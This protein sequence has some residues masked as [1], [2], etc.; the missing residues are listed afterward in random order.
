MKR[1]QG[2]HL[3]WAKIK[4]EILKAIIDGHDTRE[5]LKN[6]FTNIVTRKDIDYHLRGTP[7]KPGLIRRGVLKE[8]DGRL[9]INLRN[10]ESLE[11]ILKDYLLGLPEYRRALDL[12]FSAC[13]LSEH[14]DFLLTHFLTE[15][16]VLTYQ[17]YHYWATYNDVNKGEVEQRFM[18]LAEKKFLE[19]RGAVSDEYKISY[20]VAFYSLMLLVPSAEESYDYPK[21]RKAYGELPISEI[22][23]A[24][25]DMNFICEMAKKEHNIIIKDVFDRLNSLAR[26]PQNPGTFIGG[27][28]NDPVIYSASSI[29]HMIMYEGIDKLYFYA[30]LFSW[31]TT[32]KREESHRKEMIKIM[33]SENMISAKESARLG[34]ILKSFNDS[35]PEAIRHLMDGV[36]KILRKY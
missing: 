11:E 20:I 25:K 18:G 21:V 36:E 1:E 7:E 13:Y 29:F 12:E 17:D 24:W 4:R 31:I 22:T 28:L 27:K 26:N 19:K 14:G 15:Y 23:L 5:K 10:Y 32:S 3:G 16:E 2:K 34:S 35:Q 8:K 30:D 9:I 6:L 33:K